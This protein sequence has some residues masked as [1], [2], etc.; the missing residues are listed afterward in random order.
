M[1]DHYEL[2]VPLMTGD[3][4]K[5]DTVKL[6]KHEREPCGHKHVLY[7]SWTFSLFIIYSLGKQLGK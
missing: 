3:G 6:W 7:L 2:L 5:K 1:G 4:F